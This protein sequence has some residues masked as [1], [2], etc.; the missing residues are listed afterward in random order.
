MVMLMSYDFH[1]VNRT[2]INAPL[3]REENQNPLTET[4]SENIDIIE[5]EGCPLNKLGKWFAPEYCE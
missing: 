4:I 1:E 3:M 5:E 2:S